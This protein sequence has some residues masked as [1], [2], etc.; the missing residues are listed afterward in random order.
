MKRVIYLTAMWGMM[1]SFL[2]CTLNDDDRGGGGGGQ[3]PIP[4][5][6]NLYITS[7][8]TNTIGIVNFVPNNLVLSSYTIGSKDNEGVFYDKDAD[9]LVIVSREQ[10]A[11]NTY[12]NIKDK[13]SGEL[14]LMLSSNA[15][16]QS[17]RDIAVKNNVYV[18]SDNA[19]VDGDPT[20]EDGRFFVFTRDN[21]GYTLRNTVTVD[22]SVW[23]IQ[24]IGD[25][26]YTVVDNTGDLAVLKDFLTT[27]T[28][29]VTAAADKRITIEGVNRIHGIC[30]DKGNVVVTD[31]G[32]ASNDTDGAFH[33]IGGFIS[34]FN[35]TPDGGLLDLVGKQVRVSGG[36]TKMG[37][38]V[39]VDYDHERRTVC[40]AER[41]NSGG[42]V[43]LFT[44][45]GAGGNMQPS[46]Q[47]PFAGASSLNFIDR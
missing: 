1:F 21:N 14:N 15:V 40:I 25:D 38:P 8:T 42:N 13:T 7:N 33:F 36:M 22:Y 29:D 26:L 9:E 19:D 11:I 31:I 41:T 17:P 28:T 4:I 6:A 27:Y 20:T 24:F 23:G 37:N 45:I 5:L 3:T 16:L 2:S 10:K 43:L 44:D 46:F 39:G 30:E 18:V 12:G 34:K 47:Q 32:D 35:D